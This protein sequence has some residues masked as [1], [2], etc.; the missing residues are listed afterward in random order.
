M[1]EVSID[2]IRNIIKKRNFEAYKNQFG[3]ALIAAG[4]IGKIG[5]SVLAS[6]ACLRSG[7]GLLTVCC[8]DR[9]AIIFHSSIPEVMVIEGNEHFLT[10][11]PKNPV[12]S[13]YG[14]GPGLGLHEDTISALYDFLKENHKPCILD[15][16]A[17]NAIALKP[18][19]KKYLKNCV[20][21]PHIGEFKRLVGDWSETNEAHEKIFRFVKETL[22]I[23]VLKGPNTKIFVPDGRV[24]I[25]TTGNPGMAKAG[26]GDVLTGIITAFLAQG[27]GTVNASIL[28]VYIHGL[29]ADFAVRKS[30][31][32]S[33]LA[34]DIC[35]YLPL[36]FRYVLGE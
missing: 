10:V 4:S 36:A 35:D 33:L 2:F 25:N 12:F 5:A 21:T 32:Y 23:L 3:H 17:I 29:A 18:D 13:A 30:S 22:S 7:A 28:G 34:S 20:L 8:P 11:I 24:F 9:N 6:K 31:N 14:I 19:I 27:Y 16:D 1:Q 26:S 15:A